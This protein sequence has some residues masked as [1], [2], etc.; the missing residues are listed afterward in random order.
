MDVPSAKELMYYEDKDGLAMVA[1]NSSMAA[2]DEGMSGYEFVERVEGEDNLSRNKLEAGIHH[3]V[4]EEDKVYVRLTATAGTENVSEVVVEEVAPLSPA[5]DQVSFVLFRSLG[6]AEAAGGNRIHLI[7]V[8]RVGVPEEGGRGDVQLMK[9]SMTQREVFRGVF[10]VDTLVAECNVLHFPFLRR[11]P[12]GHLVHLLS[13]PDQ[14][15]V[16]DGQH[17][18]VNK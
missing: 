7:Q 11:F 16:Q 5:N 15:L 6:M 3:A 2:A 14:P 10:R 1:L 18:R 13:A 9:V 12:C 4:P 8:D 17:N